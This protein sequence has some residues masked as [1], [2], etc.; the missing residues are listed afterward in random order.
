M[1]VTTCGPKAKNKGT[2]FY[3]SVIENG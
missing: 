1:V 2:V 3:S